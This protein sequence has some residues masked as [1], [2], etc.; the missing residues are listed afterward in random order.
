MYVITRDL[1]KQFNVVLLASKI[2]VKKLLCL[3]NV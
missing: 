1:D 2:G 3:G